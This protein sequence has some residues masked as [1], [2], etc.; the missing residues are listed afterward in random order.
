[1]DQRIQE[2]AIKAREH[3]EKWL[4][5][6]TKELKDAGQFYA[7]LHIVAVYTQAKIDEFIAKGYDKHKAEELAL[8]LYILLEPEIQSPPPILH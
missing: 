5:R 3:W 8:P 1:M 2:L 6:K 4:P 7:A